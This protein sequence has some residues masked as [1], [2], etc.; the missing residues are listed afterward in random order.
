MKKSLIAAGAIT[1]L[2]LLS[3]PNHFAQYP[4][5]PKSRLGVQG[6]MG[7]IIT[8]VQ[9][10]STA[11]QAGLKPGDIITSTSLNGQV[12][13]G[14]QFQKDIATSA[15]GTTIQIT[16]LRFNS[17][18]GN[19]E[20]RTATVRT[21]PIP[22]QSQSS[23]SSVPAKLGRSLSASPLQNNCYWCCES[24]NGLLPYEQAS[25]DDNQGNR[26]DQL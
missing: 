8:A 5:K 16:Y 12:T 7:F 14:E 4:D 2:I 1:V 18:T 25:H 17:V 11:E 26:Q 9:P 6:E 20:E 13:S 10:G 23:A 3:A 22:S 19:F 24:C 21:M 15:A